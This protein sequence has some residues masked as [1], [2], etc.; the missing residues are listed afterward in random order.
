M[1]LQYCDKVV[2]GCFSYSTEDYVN[3]MKMTSDWIFIICL[4]IGVVISMMKVRA[5]ASKFKNKGI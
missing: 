3:A 4:S 1:L 5:A 2:Q